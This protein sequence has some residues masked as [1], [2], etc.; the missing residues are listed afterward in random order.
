M[1]KKLFATLTLVALIATLMLGNVMTAY[2]AVPGIPPSPEQ[3]QLQHPSQVRQHTAPENTNYIGEEKAKTIAL[4]T[5]DFSESDVSNMRVKLKDKKDPAYY[6]VKF[7]D[8]LIKYEVE[9]RAT[10]G[11]ILEIEVDH[12]RAIQRGTG[13]TRISEADAKRTALSAA[14]VAESET[15][16]MRVKLENKKNCNAKYEVKFTV[17]S[18]RYEYKIDAFNSMILEVEINYRRAV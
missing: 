2:A 3:T 18:V 11:E 1:K 16:S 7:N 14:D 15:T 5:F 12:S 13:G 10:D 17:D 6:E 4:S 8:D 9:V